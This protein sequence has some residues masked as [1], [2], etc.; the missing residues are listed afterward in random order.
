MSYDWFASLDYL[1]NYNLKCA[2]LMWNLRSLIFQGHISYFVNIVL[3]VFL[4][5]LFEKVLSFRIDFAN[6]FESFHVLLWFIK[7]EL[8]HIPKMVEDPFVLEVDEGSLL[9]FEYFFDFLDDLLILF[10]IKHFRVVLSA[11]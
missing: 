7:T 3:Q 10:V 1:G 4:S 9:I 5:L 8:I 2:N 6:V 11:L